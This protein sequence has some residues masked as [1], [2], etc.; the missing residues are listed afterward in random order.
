LILKEALHQASKTLASV[1]TEDATLE[2]ELLVMHL[3][4]IDRAQLYCRLEEEL[5]PGDVHTLN[6]LLERRLGHEPIAYI[7]GRREFFGNDFYVAPGV[8]IPRAESELLVEKALDFVFSDS[9]RGSE[10]TL[11]SNEKPSVLEKFEKIAD[12][13]TGCGAIAISLA[14]LLPQA[15][16]Y[17]TDISPRALEIATINCDRHRVRDRVHLLEGDLLDPLPEPVDIIIANPPYIKDADLSQL[18][19]EIRMFEPLSALAG[20][21]DGL[22]KV[23]QLLGQARGKLRPGGLVLAEI[24]ADQGEAAA[25]WARELLPHARV[26]LAKDLGGWDRVLIAGSTLTI[27]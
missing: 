10:K 21:E 6:Q 14:L 11:L 1:S 4:G 2:A 8:L 20:G 5:P 18:S 16:I 17:A 24:A 22:D 7:I 25:S 19:P 23:R 26:E 9:A 15:R 13:G 27:G 3:L 12:I